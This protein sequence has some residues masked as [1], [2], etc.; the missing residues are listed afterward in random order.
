M[1][2]NYFGA[3]NVVRGVLR[4]F[5]TLTSDTEVGKAHSNRLRLCLVSSVCGQLGLYAFTA[6]CGTK[7]ALRGFAESLQFEL[8]ELAELSKRRGADPFDAKI[9]VAHPPD[10]DTPG[11]AEENRTKPLICRKLSEGAP[12]CSATHVAQCILQ[13]SA[14]GTF[15]SSVGLEGRLVTFATSGFS[16]C[17]T[18]ADALLHSLTASLCRL[19]ALVVLHFTMFPLVRK[20]AGQTEAA[21][22][23]KK[24][25]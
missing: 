23:D 18:F 17:F 14:D 10:T 16:P 6:Y 3:V 24:K 25:Q 21:T 8:L 7:Y 22:G 15:L 13:D 20:L 19:V 12:V 1:R 4:R 11:F 2:V 5:I 9:T